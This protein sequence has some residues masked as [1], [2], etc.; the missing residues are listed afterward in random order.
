MLRESF[1]QI[2]SNLRNSDRSNRPTCHRT[3]IYDA[4]YLYR[5]HTQPNNMN[6]ECNELKQQSE[7]EQSF[8]IL[9]SHS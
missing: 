9:L 7:T 1:S 3:H 4:Q 2:L 6:R 5:K 8:L